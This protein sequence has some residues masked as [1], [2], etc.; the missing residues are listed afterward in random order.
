MNPFR[1]LLERRDDPFREARATRRALKRSKGRI[2]R[3]KAVRAALKTHPRP[4]KKK[5]TVPPKKLSARSRLLKYKHGDPNL[6][7][8]R[9]NYAGWCALGGLIVATLAAM[10]IFGLSPGDERIDTV[11]VTLTALCLMPVFSLL[12]YFLWSS[13]NRKS[14]NQ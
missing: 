8:N 13:R 12:A 1:F 11:K 4:S 5:Q 6:E 9:R 3:R 2:R 7:K 14:D 10:L